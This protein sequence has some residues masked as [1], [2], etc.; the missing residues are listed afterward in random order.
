MNRKQFLKRLGIGAVAVVVAPKALI[1]IS[2]KKTLRLW[3][4]ERTQRKLHP[5]TPE[6]RFNRPI[7]DELYKRYGDESLFDL[8]KTMGYER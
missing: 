4:M 7:F 3:K 6:E 1:E 2:K 8:L 5:L